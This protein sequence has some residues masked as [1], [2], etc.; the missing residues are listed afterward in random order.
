MGKG[1]GPRLGM[2]KKKM[3]IVTVLAV[4]FVT[5]GTTAPWWGRN[6]AEAA[7]SA[8]RKTIVQ[9]TGTAGANFSGY[10]ICHGK[11]TTVCGVLPSTF[12]GSGISQ[13]EFRKINR[14]DVLVLQV[15]DG[16]SYLHYAAP[17]GTRG[18]RAA[19]AA[20]GWNAGALRR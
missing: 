17:A 18:L 15:R 2:R 3:M 7:Q 20:S 13:C 5:T 11:R 4:L 9:L 12:S 1:A 14:D 6:S 19:T 8:S 10:Y 16:N